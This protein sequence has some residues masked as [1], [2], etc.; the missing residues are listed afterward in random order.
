[1]IKLKKILWLEAMSMSV[2]D[3][4]GRGDDPV[5]NLQTPFLFDCFYDAPFLLTVNSVFN[6]WII[7]LAFLS[8]KSIGKNSEG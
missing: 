6:I 3:F 1:M 8:L 2:L 7:C 4:G 5:E